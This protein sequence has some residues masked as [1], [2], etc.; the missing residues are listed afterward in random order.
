M[1]NYPEV[2]AEIMD[3]IFADYAQDIKVIF[4]GTKTKSDNYDPFR[5]VGYEESTQNPIYI[6][7]ITKS[8]SFNALVFKEIGLIESGAK[9]IIV[10][11]SDVDFLKLC[12]KLIINEQPYYIYH[13]AVGSKF[14]KYP[15][16]FGYTK[17][18]VFLKEE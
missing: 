18:V 2:T 16:Q 12:Q 4:R 17:I 9:N 7:A 15:L 5:D 6:K 13:D 14:Q 1:A 10:K 11:D 8:V 3:E